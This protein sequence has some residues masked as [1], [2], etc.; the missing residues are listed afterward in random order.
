VVY[1][2][3]AA[4]HGEGGRARHGLDMDRG[5]FA[6]R[7]RPGARP[8]SRPYW[9]MTPSSLGS[10]VTSRSR[11]MTALRVRSKA[12]GRPERRISAVPVQISRTVV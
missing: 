9:R 6:R 3:R 10:V 8:Y 7:R 11:S 2:G 4:I 12:A 1:A 5:W